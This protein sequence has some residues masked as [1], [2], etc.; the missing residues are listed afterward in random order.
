M[1]AALLERIQTIS[2]DSEPLRVVDVPAPVPGFGEIVLRVIACGIC[3]TEL[4]EIE[5]RTPP[6]SFPVI[7]GHE[8]V[9]EVI[10]VDRSVAAIRIGDRMG[11]GWIWSTCGDCQW[12]SS[13]LENL[14][15]EFKA[16]GRDAHGG[17]AEYIRV[18]ALSAFSIPV[19]LSSIQAAPLMC[20]GAIG[21]RSL[22]ICGLKNGQRLGLTGFGGSGHLVLK[23]VRHLYPDSDVYVFARSESERHF[24]LELGAKWSGDTAD[25]SP[26]KLNAV[27]D[28][29]PAWRPVLEALG[30]LL[31]GGRLVINAIRKEEKDREE[32]LRLDYSRDLWMEKEIKSVANVCRSDIAEFLH[33]AEKLEIR[34]EVTTYAL[35]DVNRALC[36]LKT[37]AV[38]GAKVLDIG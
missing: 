10:A 36:E 26:E 14:C 13:G 21:Y 24:A 35:E 38:R 6:P 8:V 31:P 11:V 32:L 18:P 28:T 19:G 33:L 22:N 20:A 1:R 2:A 3:H 23:L 4:D 16:T 34:P 5:G 7:P 9:G 29:T 30:N 37:T 15:P 12:C 27:I 25:R 17:Y